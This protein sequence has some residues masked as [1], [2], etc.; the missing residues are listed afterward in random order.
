MPPFAALTLAIILIVWLV[1]QDSR[2]RGSI[3]WLPFIWALTHG[4]RPVSDWFGAEG[5]Q[6]GG[7]PIEAGFTLIMITAAFFILA[8]RNFPLNRMLAFNVAFSVILL[9]FAISTVWAPYP[10]VAFKRW[11][12]ELGNVL[13]IL[14]FLSEQNPAEA[15]KIIFV[16]CSYILFPLSIVFMKYYPAIGRS[17]SRAGEWMITGVTSQKNSL[18]LICAVF[19]LTLIWDIYDTRDRY[20]KKEA[21]SLNRPK[22]ISIA[23]GMFLL[24]AC[25]SQTSLL[26]LIVGTAIFMATYLKPIRKA[27]AFYARL[28]AISVAGMLAVAALWTATAAPLLQAM[29]RDASFTGRS[30]IWEVVLQQEINPVV[31]CGFY[32]FFIE[33]GDDVWAEF[34]EFSANSAHNGYLEIY[35]DGGIVGCVLLGCFLLSTLGRLSRR[36]SH[37]DSYSRYLFT[38]AVVALIMNFSESYFFRLTLIW[39]M[40]VYGSLAHAV[41]GQNQLTNFAGSD[42]RNAEA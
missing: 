4:S 41:I 26:A 30:K 34:F 25:N 3:S 36:Y 39:I 18:G 22:W 1:W 13:V 42:F 31:G 21:A 37:E 32:S 27:P 10:F 2:H 20:P 23:M 19:I 14:V 15:L 38:L 33:K 28:T 12:K 29:G 5:S 16:R 11:F 7:N 24:I 17:M 8:R 9:Y 40:L 6:L 35:L